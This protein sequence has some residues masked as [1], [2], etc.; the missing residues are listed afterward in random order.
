MY[1]ILDNI[2]NEGICTYVGYRALSIF[3][4]EAERDY[5]MLETPEEV[6]R[7]FTE[8]NAVLSQYG[9]LPEDEISKLSGDKGVVGRTYYVTG[10]YI[11]QTIDEQAGRKTLIDVYSKEPLAIIDL[12]N[13]LVGIEQRLLISKEALQSFRE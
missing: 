2:V 3:P 9:Q 11:C 7:Q 5:V 13:K 1:N 6:H 10:A 4:V 8:S 12:Y